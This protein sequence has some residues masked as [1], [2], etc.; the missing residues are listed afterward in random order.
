MCRIGFRL[1]EV[2]V[3]ALPVDQVLRVAF[4]ALPPHVAV[5]GECDIGEHRV[6]GGNGAHGVR[7]RL[8]AG[9][10]R[11][12][13]E[14]EFRVDG[15]QATVLAKSHPCDVVS[16]CLRT[17]AGD[18]WLQHRQVGLATRRRECGREVV[19]LVLRRN[20]LEDQHVLGQPALIVG[21]RRRDTQ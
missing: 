5:V 18:G 2:P 19:S 9:A 12:P 14:A 3:V 1:A 21:H 13:E 6:A 8:P 20:Q 16:E 17:P 10:R 4:Q 11:H 15:V 7:V